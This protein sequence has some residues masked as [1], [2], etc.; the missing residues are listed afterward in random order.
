MIPMQAARRGMRITF[1]C[2]LVLASIAGLGYAYQKSIPARIAVP[3]LAAF[4]AE[5]ALYA[6]AVIDSTRAAIERWFRGPA[7]AAVMTASATVPYLLYAIPT[8]MFQWT[9]VAAILALGA[10]VSW[11]YVILPPRP[12]ANL[13]FVSVVAAVLLG[14]PFDRI[15]QTP[16]PRGLGVLGN[17]GMWTRLSILAVLSIARLEVKGFGFVP[18]RREWR[19]GIVNFLLF[20]VPG[21][22]IAWQLDFA[23][24]HPPDIPWWLIACE[25]AGIFVGMLWVVALREEFFLRGLLQ[26]WLGSWF[27][28]ETVGLIVSALVFGLCHLRFRGFPNWRI[29]ILAAVAGLFYGRAYRNAA[30]VRAAM[31]SH[32]L[33]NAAW[34]VLF[35]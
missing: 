35:W 8:G 23:K 7:L 33:V 10:V 18:N 22:L 28:N 3:L 14:V 4:L 12:W 20:L 25:L 13:A 29:V 31:V 34:R 17:Y 5:I 11:W 21:A 15:Y 1:L 6:A 26:P 9:S 32:A 24:F 19:E 30:S 2:V 16:G 27:R